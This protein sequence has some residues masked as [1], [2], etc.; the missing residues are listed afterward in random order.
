M[1]IKDENLMLIARIMS[2]FSIHT[3]IV[4]VCKI[5]TKKKL[6]LL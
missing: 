4:T 1:K 5:N 6:N 2:T 3:S